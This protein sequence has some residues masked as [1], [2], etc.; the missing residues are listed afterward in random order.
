MVLRSSKLR[1]MISEP[2]CEPF[3]QWSSKHHFIP[4]GLLMAMGTFVG[5]V[6]LTVALFGKGRL[7]TRS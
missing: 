6:E 3:N 4:C 7:I 1:F 2:R 5:V